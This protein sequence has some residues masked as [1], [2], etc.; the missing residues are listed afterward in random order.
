MKRFKKILVATDTRLEKNPIV[1]E[2]AEIAAHNGASLKIVDVVPPFSWMARYTTQD[3]EHLSELIAKEKTEILTSLADEVAAKGIEVETKILRGKASTE[4]TLETIRGD[5]DLVMAVA[6]GQQSKRDGFFG[7]TALRLLRQCPAAVWLVA[8][9]STPSPKHILGC[10]DTASE[11]A[12]DNELNE[13]IVEL[14]QTISHYHDA[15]FSV[16]HA[17]LLEDI[18]LLRRRSSD[19]AIERYERDEHDYH[20]NKLDKFLMRYDLSTDAQNVHLINKSTEEAIANFVDSNGVDLLVMGT[21]ARKGLGGFLIGNLAEKILD[22]IECSVLALKPYGF[23]SS[24]D[25]N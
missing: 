24:V 3:H 2:A 12:I 7:Y 14:S 20:Q 4:I 22:E 23:Q 18:E 5:H 25:P 21:V 8:P 1:D 9:D 16:L 6:K 11:K 17:W 10:V 15:R 13:K 19:D